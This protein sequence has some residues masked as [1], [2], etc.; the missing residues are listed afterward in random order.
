M[1]N[2]YDFSAVRIIHLV[3]SFKLNCQDCRIALL[4]NSAPVELFSQKEHE[5][6][7]LCGQHCLHTG[8]VPLSH[9]QHGPHSHQ[10]CCTILFLRD[11]LTVCLCALVCVFVCV[12]VCVC[13]RVQSCGSLCV[14]AQLS[15][16]LTGQT[17]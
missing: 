5:F 10:I 11:R 4:P 12:C 8:S 7:S 2:S 1:S 3:H 6:S 15:S 17:E 9:S 16:L 14:H 13:V